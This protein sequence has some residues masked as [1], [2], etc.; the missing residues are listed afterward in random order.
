[1]TVGRRKEPEGNEIIETN[2]FFK[3]HF[4]SINE[5]SAAGLDALNI[6]AESVKQ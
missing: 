3:L 6:Y 1:M 5:N 2:F 4:F